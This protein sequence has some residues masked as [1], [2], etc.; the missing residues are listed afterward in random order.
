VE[1]GAIVPSIATLEKYARAVEISMYRIF[2]D[3]N[4]AAETTRTTEVNKRTRNGVAGPGSGA[5]PLHQFRRVL[6]ER[7]N[8][9]RD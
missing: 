7:K 9:I 8:A 3:G 1:N 6:R 4:E 5:K 2:Y